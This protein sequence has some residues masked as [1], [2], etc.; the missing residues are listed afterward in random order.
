MIYVLSMEPQAYQ[1][2]VYVV[3]MAQQQ[4]QYYQAANPMGNYM[5]MEQQNYEP[6]NPSRM[7]YAQVNQHYGF[8]VHQPVTRVRNEPQQDAPKKASL[9]SKLTNNRCKEFFLYGTCKNGVDCDK[10]HCKDDVL[11]MEY[12]AQANKH[13]G[14]PVRQPVTRVQTMPQQDARRKGPLMKPKLTYTRCKEFFLYGT[15]KNGVHCDKAHCLTE[16]KDSEFRQAK[17]MKAIMRRRILA[18]GKNPRGGENNC[19]F[20]PEESLH[21]TP[22]EEQASSTTRQTTDSDSD[23]RSSEHSEMADTQFFEVNDPPGS[24]SDIDWKLASSDWKPARVETDGLFCASQ[25]SKAQRA[26]SDLGNDFTEPIKIPENPWL[27]EPISYD[28]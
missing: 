17:C 13:Y 22:R 24:S 3:N 19:R 28:I 5:M 21:K 14:V 7:Q 4:Q 18:S 6:N 25:A 1:P 15:C 2:T 11:R 16:L 10:A 27:T 8:P 23:V 12:S 20:P 9:K 26:A